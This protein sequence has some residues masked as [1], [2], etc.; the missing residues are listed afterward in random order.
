VS[1]QAEIPR[2]RRRRNPINGDSRA[3]CLGPKDVNE[4]TFTDMD[5]HPWAIVQWRDGDWETVMVI[6]DG[7]ESMHVL[8]ELEAS[9]PPEERMP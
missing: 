8:R 4:G 6:R 3:Y 2:L 1:A 9:R 7:R 5:L